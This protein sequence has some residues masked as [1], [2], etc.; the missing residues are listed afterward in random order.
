M[1]EEVDFYVMKLVPPP[2]A[3]AAG[4]N[5]GG[6]F[7]FFLRSL[8]PQEEAIALFLSMQSWSEVP[9][10]RQ[11]LVLSYAQAETVVR[12]LRPTALEEFQERGFVFQ[13]SQ[14]SEDD[15]GAFDARRFFR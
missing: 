3:G 13:I 15:D 11:Q 14:H 4:I 6:L 7:A 12:S 5:G 8:Q 9:G 2:A 10:T 1:S